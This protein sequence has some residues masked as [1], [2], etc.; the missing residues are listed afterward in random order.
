MLF[1]Y[2]HTFS[3]KPVK[4]ICGLDTAVTGSC[5]PLSTALTHQI[6][7][8][9]HSVPCS[10]LLLP[11]C[12]TGVLEAA[13][14]SDTA[15]TFSCHLFYI[16]LLNAATLPLKGLDITNWHKI[17][18][19]DE[20]PLYNLGIL[21][22]RKMFVRIHT[23]NGRGALLEVIEHVIKDLIISTQIKEAV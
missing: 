9:W 23:K 10:L 6:N 12:Q 5:L 1:C 2:L 14:N 8:H 21:N 18:V 19:A 22:I 11:T 15:C 7:H 3:F 4:Y 16:S 20:W 17:I 13:K